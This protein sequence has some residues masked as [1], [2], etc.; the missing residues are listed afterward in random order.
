MILSQFVSLIIA[1]AFHLG[2]I[3][4]FALNYYWFYWAIHLKPL[5]IES[6]SQSVFLDKNVILKRK[7]NGKLYFMP[8]V[9]KEYAM[10]RGISSKF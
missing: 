3:C 7:E 9:S 4:L 6:L 10:Q 1:I 2:T 5:P 8:N